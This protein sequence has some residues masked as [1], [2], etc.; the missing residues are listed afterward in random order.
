MTGVE[1]D[2]G[3]E[4]CAP[5]GWIGPSEGQWLASFGFESSSGVI[6]DVAAATLSGH[7]GGKGQDEWNPGAHIDGVICNWCRGTGE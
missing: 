3:G 1:E 7:E 2:G 4:D 6:D 5:A